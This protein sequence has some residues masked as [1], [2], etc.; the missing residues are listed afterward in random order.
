MNFDGDLMLEC[1]LCGCVD[2]D[3]TYTCSA[4]ALMMLVQPKPT[5][6]TM[7][8]PAPQPSGLGV[9]EQSKQ[10]VVGVIQTPCTGPC[11]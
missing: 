7:F 6:I 5:G 4:P 10:A 2:S 8:A 9:E 1:V 3:A 11:F